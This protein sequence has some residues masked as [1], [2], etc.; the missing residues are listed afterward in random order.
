MV[1]MRSKRPRSAASIWRARLGRTMPRLSAAASMRRSAGLPT[2]QLPV[3]A[4][5]TTNW[6]SRPSRASR[7]KNT[8]SAAGERQMLPR[9]TNSRRWGDM[10]RSAQHGWI[11]GI[12]VNP[13]PCKGKGSMG[14]Q[15]PSLWPLCPPFTLPFGQKIAP[16]GRAVIGRSSRRCACRRLGR[17]LPRQSSACERNDG[18]FCS[19]PTAPSGRQRR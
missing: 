19:R 8:P 15:R 13:C 18:R 9:Q 7:C 11:G 17:R 16:S 5:S 6:S 1:R 2:C 12:E 14:P 10:A 3:P 4:E